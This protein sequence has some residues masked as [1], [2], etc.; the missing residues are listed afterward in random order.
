MLLDR[1]IG[2]PLR[3]VV[4]FNPG[5]DG[6]EIMRLLHA[7]EIRAA[8]GQA[9]CSPENI[10]KKSILRNLLRIAIMSVKEHNRFCSL[11]APK[12]L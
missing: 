6:T 5:E 2:L 1:P 4:E 11:S 12:P 10:P 8:A 3:C 7:K 9:V